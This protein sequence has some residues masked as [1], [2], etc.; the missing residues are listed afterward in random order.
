MTST[1]SRPGPA[2]SGAATE[3]VNQTKAQGTDRG[4]LVKAVRDAAL[5]WHDAGFCAIPA[6]SDGSKAPGL[7]TW[8]QYQHEQYPRR[9]LEATA[10]QG[11]GLICGAVSGGLEMFELEGLAVTEGALDHVVQLIEASGLGD[12]WRR[13]NTA[14]DAYVERT[15]SGGFHWLCRIGDGD[16]PGN[17]KLARRPAR[18][19]ELTAAERGLRAQKPDKVIV[20]VLAET[21]GE[22]GFSVTAPSGGSTHPSRRAW[23][24]LHGRPGVVP[25]ITLAEREHLARLFRTLDQM[26][27]PPKRASSDSSPRPAGAGL[28]PGDDFEAR[29]DWEDELLLGGAGWEVVT[30]RGDGYRTWRRPGKDRGISATTGQAADRDRLYVFST[31]TEFDD[32]APITKFHAYAVMHHDGYHKGAAQELRRLGYGAQ[33][34]QTAAGGSGK[35]Q[36]VNSPRDA[37]PGAAWDDPLPLDWPTQLPAFPV[38]ALPGVFGEYAAA[39]AVETQTPADLPGVVIVGTLAASIG[40]R[41]RVAVR[42]GWTEPTNLFAVPVLPP[43]SRKS[44]VVSACEAPLDAAEKQL[45]EELAPQIRNAMIEREIREKYADQ[46]KQKAGKQP[47]AMLLL[48]AQEAGRVAAETVVPAWP[49]LLAD[50]ATPEAIVKLLADQGGRIAAMSAEA[51]IFDSLA[52]RYTSKSNLEPMLKA[53]AGDSIRVDRRSREP[54][55]VDRP[56]LTMVASIQP[57]ALHDMVSR[58]EF[59]GRGLLAR[60]LWSLPADLV[61]YR[62]ENAPPVPESLTIRYQRYVTALAVDMYKRTDVVHLSLSET[63]YK[64]L[65]DYMRQVEIMLRADGP[66]GASRLLKDWGSKLVGAVA[67]ISGGLHVALGLDALAHPISDSTMESAVAIGEYFRA[68]ATGALRNADEVR[69]EEVSGSARTLLTYLIGKDLASFVIRDLRSGPKA[70][71]AAS[72]VRPVIDQLTELGWLREAPKGGWEVHPDAESRLK[73]GD[74][75]D[76]GD[77]ENVTP[78]QDGSYPVAPPVAHEGDRGD[79]PQTPTSVTA[80]TVAPVAPWGDTPG[81]TTTTGLS[82]QNAPTVAPVAPVAPTPSDKPTCPLCHGPVWLASGKCQSECTN[83]NY[84]LQCRQ[85]VSPMAWGSCDRC[86]TRTHSRGRGS[87]GQPCQDCLAQTSER[88]SA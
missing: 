40:G 80:P 84:C 16:V 53:H 14:D 65:I 60:V 50:D 56:A 42:R 48:D 58:P 2:K 4:D 26:P 73:A 51:G 39:L 7:S 44:A 3:Q 12:L 43:G 28:S 30:G 45:L 29:T 64:V 72:A 46:Q 61:G 23:T 63:A 38:G 52:G 27:A 86:G 77:S 22:G 83:P 69:G 25:T 36:P 67:R 21:R 8:T 55:R 71:R 20:R 79:A 75:G 1:Q 85:T 5:A 37:E 66:L 70:L 41:V 62:D 57:Y 11:F 78:G 15:P 35:E 18:D 10:G 54:E 9:K 33:R 13:L 76:R 49:R 34:E 87:H 24:V 68:H 31:S 59:A 88:T 19:D 74:R 81:D 82:S 17:T 6:K 32:L 47:D